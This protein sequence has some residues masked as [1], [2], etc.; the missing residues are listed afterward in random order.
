MTG[1]AFQVARIRAHYS[2]R[3]AAKFLDV[4]VR[5]IQNWEARGKVPEKATRIQ[6]A[7]CPTCGAGQP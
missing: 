6:V 4:S 1:R 2:Y 7:P 3:Q 5:T